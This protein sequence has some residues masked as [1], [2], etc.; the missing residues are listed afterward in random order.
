MFELIL[1]SLTRRCIDYPWPVIILYVLLIIVATNFTVKNIKINTNTEDMLSAELT[2][3]KYHSEYKTAFPNTIDNVILIVESSKSNNVSLATRIL[4]EKLRA[5]DAFKSVFAIEES[6]FFK[7]NKLLYLDSEELDELLPKLVS[8]Q[9]LLG[10]LAQNK[11]FLGIL[12]L[13]ENLKQN[14]T[15]LNISEAELFLKKIN[16]S[17]DNTINNI[18]SPIN[19]DSLIEEPNPGI[20]ANQ[21]VFLQPK[22]NFTKLIP[23]EES[24]EIIN[25]IISE[26]KKEVIDPFHVT[27]TG[28]AALAYDELKSVSNGT[29]TSGVLALL[30]VLIIL[31]IAFKSISI[32][33]AICANLLA[34]L[35]LT[36][37]YATLAV[38]T[39]NMISIA[40]A[41]LYIGLAVDFAIHICMMY[42]ENCGEKEKKQAIENAITSLRKSLF[43][44]TLTTSIGF[45]SFI[46]TDYRGVAEL[47][48]IS[49]VGM[50][51][52]LI[53]SFTFLPSLL[54]VLP[55]PKIY[56]S[57]KKLLNTNKTFYMAKS[58]TYILF[59]FAIAG[60]FNIQNLRFDNNPINLNNKNA[61]SVNGL[62]KLETLNQDN[63][64]SVSVLI[65]SQA[66]AV[67]FTDKQKE[68]PEIEK[69]EFIGNYIP[70]EQEKKISLIEEI[71]LIFGG[72]I[73]I[74]QQGSIDSDFY[75]ERIAIFLQDFK[76]ETKEESLLIHNI[77][78]LL[79]K[80][81]QLGEHEKNKVFKHL[82]ENIFYYFEDFIY[83]ISLALSAETVDI[84]NLP[85][86][87]KSLWI[88]QND[89]YRVKLILKNKTDKIDIETFQQL[90]DEKRYVFSGAPIINSEAGHSVTLAFTQAIT[91]ALSII[92]LMSYVLTK[93]LKFVFALLA[94]L[95][96]ATLSMIFVLTVFSFPINFANIIALPLL[97]GIGIDSS[98]HVFHRMKK[99]NSTHSFYSTSTTKAVIYS[100]LTTSLSFGSLA[101]SSHNGTASLGILLMIGLSF[102]TVAVLSIIPNVLRQSHGT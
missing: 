15:T 70:N 21:V 11:N 81:T 45:F 37:T 9:P 79:E 68:N 98:I 53:L 69:I 87:L 1:K 99:H 16:D 63:S 3:R 71:S 95:L 93:K 12:G 55:K 25:K 56:R 58:T 83:S 42:L 43:F 36:A 100:A 22:L 33:F 34:G 50:L 72:E 57:K 76:P 13:Y 97:L 59:I 54:S 47:G 66:A 101:S 67:K 64:Y 48:L 84:S 75:H 40:F 80:I 2:W 38:G 91:T 26:T 28:G 51:L 35:M 52:S 7:Q 73:E 29:K 14:S 96:L 46:P 39:L 23:G 61:P 41:V 77:K 8:A 10:M 94:P 78:T 24:I 65:P 5:T 18:Q 27:I 90:T 86:E 20:V 44:C 88:S 6:A 32:I 49:G 19:W 60:L 62:K 74:R 92:F 4:T 102:I 89:E 31:F 30:F 82:N 17:I 85:N